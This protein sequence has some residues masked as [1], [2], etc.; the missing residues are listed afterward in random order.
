MTAAQNTSSRA[1][2][3]LGHRRGPHGPVEKPKNAK[4]TAKRLVSYF[5]TQK[6]L[7]ILL[8]LAVGLA[9]A[10]QVVAPVLQ[11]KAIDA[12]PQKDLP[13][14][15]KILE[16]L[17]LLYIL[18]ALCTLAET[19]T[20]AMLSQKVTQRM[21]AALFHR[22]DHLSIPYLDTHPGGDIMSRMTS[23][24]ENVSQTIST[25]IASFLTGILQT[26]GT[27]VLMLYLSPVLTVTVLVPV[28]ASAAATKAL[29]GVQRRAFRKRSDTLGEL[30]GYA[31][32]RISG[33]R[34][35]TAYGA[36]EPVCAEFNEISDRLAK[37]GIRAEILGGS[38]GPIMNCISNAGFVLV[39]LCGG[40]LAL[41]GSVTIGT[42]SAFLIYAKQVAR[43]IND[44]AQLFGTIQTALASAERVFALM[45]EPD[46]NNEGSI[47][48][49]HVTGAVSFDHVTFSYVPG[50][51]VLKD[52]S[53]KISPGE[54]IALVGATGSG[55]T[56][57]VNLL[58][59]FYD[60]DSGTISIDGTDIHAMDRSCLRRSTA[61]VLQDTVLFSDTIAGNI[62]FG[63]V[64]ATDEE[65]QKAAVL[66]EADPFIQLLP[67][68][69]QY[70]LR[71]AGER[72]SQGQRQLLAIARAVL[73]D[74]AILILDEATSS[75]D[76]RTEKRVQQAMTRLM[77]NRTSVI[78]AHRLSTIRDVDRI[79]VLD[80]GSIVE[81]GRHEELLA[82]KGTYY[83]LYMTQFAGK[84]I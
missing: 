11:G 9:S 31:Q 2:V 79:I 65:V 37:A 14:L 8:I 17:V 67:G 36:E 55:K 15:G 54:K 73:A 72:L 61:I 57:I 59:R 68:T 18:Q 49:E 38:T 26:I 66:A 81:S 41:N 5:G 24:V 60:P 71:R 80:H 25:S 35:I 23:D 47:V 83:R 34:T 7:L 28:L 46:E 27:I 53:L 69:Y 13:R 43:P 56:T 51:Q 82:K 50:T 33:C 78:I 75:V 10:L 39:A 12:L 19:L 22:I 74:P 76:T 32:E 64:T 1:Q 29:S 58:L 70:F 21:R 3:P 40:I 44:I 20:A 62:R 45:D 30:D 6:K 77:Q 16:V 84:T 4:G 63:R 52:F 42:V 48:P